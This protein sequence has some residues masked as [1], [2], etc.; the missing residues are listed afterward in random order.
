MLANYESINHLKDKLNVLHLFADNI[1]IED[2]KEGKNH[3][4]YLI[5][6]KKNKYVAKISK[7]KEDFCKNASK[8]KD[9]AIKTTL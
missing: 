4:T 2:L 6:D 5:S 1:T 7:S 8:I 3:T 9:N